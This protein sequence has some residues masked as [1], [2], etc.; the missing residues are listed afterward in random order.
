ML[1]K[2]CFEKITEGNSCELICCC[3]L[4]LLTKVPFPY[5]TVP[6]VPSEMIVT[7]V[8]QNET[9]ASRV[10]YGLS[11]LD[12]SA[13]GTST[14]FVDGGSL[15]RTMYIHRAKLTALKPGQKYGNF[16]FLVF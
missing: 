5:V 12:Q 4:L 3:F 13:E 8:T 15:H 16:L 10:M 1:S 2:G 7:W 11:G 14:K 6:G 9:S